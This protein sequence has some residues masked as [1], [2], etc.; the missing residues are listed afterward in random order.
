MSIAE[1]TIDAAAVGEPIPPRSPDLSS[2]PLH[3]IAEIR[4]QQG[5]SIRTVARRIGTTV[6][7][8]REQEEADSDLLLS[9]LYRWQAALD[10]PVAD[11]LVDLDGP[12]SPPVMKRA[13]MLKLMKTAMA[14]KEAAKD[15][16]VSLLA[17][18]M[19]N[20]LLEIMPELRD[21]N[22][23]PAVG[24]RRTL[25]DLG[26]TATETVPDTVFFEARP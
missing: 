5:V 6:G 21:V 16:S 10:V 18:M 25:G 23:W 11:L 12:L 3:R 1:W 13:Q 19:V 14:I 17:E 8:A 9:Q 22:P 24:Q 26:R 7:T 15:E 2:R 20:Q 4:R